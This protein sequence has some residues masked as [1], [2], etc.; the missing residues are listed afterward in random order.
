MDIFITKNCTRIALNIIKCNYYFST[1]TQTHTTILWPS[2]ILFGNTLQW[3]WQKHA[4]VN[5]VNSCCQ[6]ISQLVLIDSSTAEQ[7]NDKPRHYHLVQLI[8]LSK[9]NYAC[10]TKNVIY[11]NHSYINK[12]CNAVC[13]ML[14]YPNT[15]YNEHYHHTTTTITTTTS[16][17]VFHS[18][19]RFSQAE[20][21]EVVVPVGALMLSARQEEVHLAC[22][23]LIRQCQSLPTLGC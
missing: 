15:T 1:H 22:K 17:L 19:S 3:L 9:L 21:M 16:G 4:T 20:W 10:Q 12:Q 18:Y 13:F 14:S 5:Y 8:W 2:W 11:N 6:P 23:T 7:K